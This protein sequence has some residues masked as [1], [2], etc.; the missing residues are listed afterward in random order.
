MCGIAGYVGSQALGG[1]RV[2]G[3][4][5]AMRHRGP[6]HAAHRHWSTRAEAH[7]HLLH[8]RLNIID[9]NPRSNQPFRV[10]SKWVAYNGELYNY[11]EVRADLARQGCAFTT[12]SDT[13][14]LLQAIDRLG[15][16]ALD[17][18]E[19]MWALAVFDEADESLT[20]CRDRFG[21]KPLY[22]Y[23]H[24]S[25]IYF[26]SEVKFIAALLG[27]RLPVN[28][29]QVYRYMVNGYKSLYQTGQTF[30]R[31]L[32]ELPSAT[33]LRL[34]PTGAEKQEAYWEPRFEPDERMTYDDAVEGTRARVIRAVEVRLRAD[35]PLAFCM[36]GGVD[37]N[38]L[39]SVAKAV[40]G[41]DVHGFTVTV[42]DARYDERVLVEAAVCRL[43]IRHTCVVADRTGF[44]P[45]LR[46][47]VRHHDAPVFT[48]SYYA[49]WLLMER[50]A[51][52][53]YRISVSGTG[54]DEL[55]TGYYDHFPAY[56][57]ET[58]EEAAGSAARRD[59]EEHVKPVVR[60]QFLRDPDLFTRD[61]AFRAHIFFD[62]ERFA[63]YLTR[64]WSEPF[65]ERT[66][67][68][69]LLR[70]RMLNE[71]F[72]ENIPVILHEDDL[73]AMYFSIENRSPFLDRALFD[74]CYRIPTRHLI[75]DGFAKAVLRDAM[76]GIVPEEVRTSR[77]KVGFNAP[78]EAFLDPRDAAVREALL[79]RSP[80]FEHVHRDRI[81]ALLSRAPLP[82]SDSKFLFYFLNSKLFLEEFAG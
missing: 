66:Y 78:I 79:D 5:A 54:S 81:E 38:A 75:R 44:L 15:W 50:I 21:E 80:I 20:L 13:E 72:H 31:G 27:R 33:V 25:G 59:W 62:S 35:V 12:E 9:L 69:R 7:V 28:F 39:I 29:D 41:Y 56:F 2:E 52:H 22:L 48:I 23:R 24:P 11:R 34:E 18:F 1:D 14:V 10:G 42:D 36:S 46:Q 63:G 6:D 19:G 45:R 47:L 67:T 60:N 8:S 53:G 64:P 70:N 16:T 32:V 71:M 82:N 37:S 17:Q 68:D 43:G 4:L 51:E 65:T 57:Y 58:R 61:P 55:F 3:C 74:F 49:H 77:R 40:F 30:F 26:G 76:H 73:N